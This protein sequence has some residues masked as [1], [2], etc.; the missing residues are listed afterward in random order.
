MMTPMYNDMRVIHCVECGKK[1]EVTTSNWKRV[2]RCIEHQ[3]KKISKYRT[4]YIKNRRAL[5]KKQKEDKGKNAEQIPKQ[6][7]I[8]NLG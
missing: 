5:L 8:P 4:G 3:Y 2:T 6:T 7:D 1:R